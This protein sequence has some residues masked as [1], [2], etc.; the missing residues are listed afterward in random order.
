[1]KYF[2]DTEFLEN[3]ATIELISIGIVADDGREYYAVNADMPVDMI[4]NHDWLSKNVW[5]NLPLRG[6]KESNGYANSASAGNLDMSSTLVK[7]KWVIANEVREFLLTSAGVP[8]LWAWYSAYDHVALAQLFGSMI[9][10]PKGLPMYTHDLRAYI[11]YEP[12]NTLPVQKDGNH[13]AL[14]DA[15]WVKE[16]YEYVTKAAAMEKAMADPEGQRL[17]AEAVALAKSQ[18]G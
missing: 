16:A 9:R 3:G 14:A 13:N 7:P 5:P 18:R 10:L 6:R 11:D 12:S 8:E 1:M 15:R 4:K 17:A 2:Y